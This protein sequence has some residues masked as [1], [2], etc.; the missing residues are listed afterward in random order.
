MFYQVLHGKIRIV[1][2]SV[3]ILFYFFS[4]FCENIFTNTIP[5]MTIPRS[6]CG[7]IT[8]LSSEGHRSG[9][10]NSFRKSVRRKNAFFQPS[11]RRTVK[12]ACLQYGTRCVG[13]IAQRWRATRSPPQIRG[14]SL[15]YRSNKHVSA[16]SF[17]HARAS[18]N[19]GSIFRF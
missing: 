12:T 11:N 19:D 2:K 3:F 6:L 15:I 10:A 1:I 17:S 18:V 4:N 8:E 9:S 13:R 16:R 5:R 7:I 14:Y